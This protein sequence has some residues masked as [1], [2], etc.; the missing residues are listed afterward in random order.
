M[1]ENKKTDFELACEKMLKRHSLDH[2]RAYGRKV[3]VDNPTEKN[4]QPLIEGIIDVLMGRVEPEPF[5]KRGAPI[6]SDYYDPQIDKD[7]NSYRMIYASSF[8]SNMK[9]YGGT[10]E[11]GVAM[12]EKFRKTLG[13]PSFTIKVKSPDLERVEDGPL[14]AQLER[15]EGVPFLIPLDGDRDGFKIVVSEEQIAKYSLREGDVVNCAVRVERGVFLVDTVLEI[16][17]KEAAEL[18]RF[19]FDEEDVYPP[20]KKISLLSG[21]PN[22]P[23]MK[24]L[25]WFI[26]IG[27]GQRCLIVSPPKAGKTSFLKSIALSLSK[28]EEYETY[29]LLVEQSPE[30]ASVFRQIFPTENFAATTYEDDPSKHVF[31]A[32]F[33][34]KRAKRA[35]E[36][37]KNVVLLVDGMNALA[38]AANEL[39]PVDEAKRPVAG[40]EMSAVRYIKKFFVSARNFARPGSLTIIATATLT[41]G[42]PI[43]DFITAELQE[44]AN[45]R[46]VLCDEFA[47]KRIYP[48]VDLLRSGTDQS[49]ELLGEESGAGEYRMRGKLLPALGKER[50]HELILLSKT[51]EE[52][53]EKA[54]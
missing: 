16:N 5:P 54:K 25:D 2:L 32:D 31:T 22:D 14:Q 11:E 21:S 43:T 15:I 19:S 53:F 41:G 40:L 17:G 34:L 18:E 33:L 24:Y 44:M 38:E 49:F 39:L 3:G 26:P 50:I 6:K 47:L 42:N 7:V 9:E 35:A 12:M 1:T 20:V 45:C 8:V 23:A 51:V 10:T 36:T 52:F 29:C 46:V 4:K 30:T 27:E 37:G 48:A 28:T 13:T